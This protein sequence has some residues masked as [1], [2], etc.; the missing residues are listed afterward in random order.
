MKK[1]IEPRR[2]ARRCATGQLCAEFQVTDDNATLKAALDLSAKH[3]WHVF[4]GLL[5]FDKAKGKWTKLSH[6]SKDNSY[7]GLNWGASRDTDQIR[8][9]FERCRP[10]AIGVPT[11]PTNG[12]WICETDT[13]AGGHDHDGEE[14]LRRLIAEHGGE[15]PDTLRSRSPSGSIHNYLKW[16][17][18]DGPTITSS[19]CE[20]APGIDVVGERGMVIAPPSRRG[21]GAYE[22]LNDNPIL[23]APAWLVEK[24]RAVSAK[25]SSNGGGAPSAD[26]EAPVEMIV[27]ALSVLSNPPDA[28][29]QRRV[30]YSRWN[31]VG[32]SAHRG[33]GGSAIVFAAF[34]A[35]SQKNL[36]KY[37]AA[38]TERKW[39][40][41]RKSPITEVTVASLFHFADEEDPDWR[42]LCDPDVVG[43]HYAEMARRDTEL[44][45][46]LNTVNDDEDA[47]YLA[48]IAA[49]ETISTNTGPHTDASEPAPCTDTC[50]TTNAD[51]K[52]DSS[53]SDANADGAPIEGA[54]PTDTVAA[55]QATPSTEAAKPDDKPNGAAPKAQA[56]P[57]KAAKPSSNTPA[58]GTPGEMTL[59]GRTLAVPLTLVDAGGGDVEQVV[60]RI[61]ERHAFVLAGNKAAIMKFDPDGKA[62]RLISIEALMAWYANKVV[63]TGE[64]DAV[65]AAKLWFTSRNR[66]EF[67]GIEFAPAGGKAG[68]YNFW[69][70]FAVESRPGDCSKFLAHVRDNI[71][72]GDPHLYSWVIGFFAQIVQQ[73]D[74]KLG[75]AL[76]IRG[77]PGVG[78]TKVGEVFGSLLKPH[79]A[80]V[81]DP[82]YVTGQ[83]NSH[84]ASLLLL[85]A[86][87]AF[88]AGDKRSEGKLKDLVTGTEHFLEFKGV[89][90]IPVHNYM[91]LFVT[92]NAD[93]LVPAAFRERRWAIIDA[94]TAHIQDHAYFAAI[95]D[96]MNN[97]GRE[98]LLHHLKTFD[99]KTVNL[100]AIPETK[101]LLEQKF[102]SATP[103]EKFWLDTL[104][105]GRLPGALEGEPSACRKEK[106][107]EAYL[108][109]ARGTGVSHRSIQVKVGMFLTDHVPGLIADQKVTHT[110][111]TPRNEKVTKQ[112]PAYKF[113]T[114]A[115]CRKAFEAK[116]KQTIDWGADVT[117][118]YADV[119]IEIEPAPEGSGF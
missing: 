4:P 118:W 55:A 5:I 17:R 95:D 25:G 82:R 107:Y 1:R 73:P 93:W 63:A 92:G 56:A 104:K 21:N 20:I 88:W 89:D 12:F 51:A 66:R 114:L 87:E 113:P 112:A 11:G 106:L 109:H 2:R 64:G 79:Y 100:R 30:N 77:E 42:E 27:A 78:K 50:T 19:Y 48:E 18:D 72:Q 101:A 115:D 26:P 68:Y 32:M 74:V 94:S 85:H 8:K 40:G 34:D 99:L 14:N 96:E 58:S 70:G 29:E 84:M 13:K 83:F 37:D 105:Y 9:E 44:V 86:D 7:S 6:R 3:D 49:R 76:A 108:Q 28:S 23:E 10:S 62:F 119:V 59:G 90:P 65:S 80:L 103:E 111:Y 43:R 71:T 39:V 16:P 22:W 57:A 75:T 116:I 41:Y 117:G 102:Q 46:S 67:E 47:R 69:Q 60:A 91:R 81:A 98:A 33:S 31:R 97:G 52:P 45:R 53:A 61:N 35:F 54:K 36:A 110:F 24:A 15:W 38:A